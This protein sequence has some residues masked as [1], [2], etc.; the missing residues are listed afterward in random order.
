MSKKKSI[1]ITDEMIRAGMD[2]FTDYEVASGHM[3][4]ADAVSNIF[5]SMFS[6]ARSDQ[7]PNQVVA[8]IQ[9]Q[10]ILDQPLKSAQKTD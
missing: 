2:A 9:P 8:S 5:L 6:C 4:M 7:S 1:K 10:A 3:S